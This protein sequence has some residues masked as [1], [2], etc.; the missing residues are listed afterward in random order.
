MATTSSSTTADPAAAP[1]ASPVPPFKKTPFALKYGPPVKPNPT[2]K[3]A[4]AEG[5]FRQKDTMPVILKSG[6]TPL[7]PMPSAAE[8]KAGWSRLEAF[9]RRQFYGFTTQELIDVGAFSLA[10][11]NHKPLE[12]PIHPVFARSRWVAKPKKIYNIEN[13]YGSVP[14]SGQNDDVWAILQPSLRLATFI[15]NK[16][17]D[18]PWVSTKSRPSTV[19]TNRRSRWML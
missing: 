6:L 8:D 19:K 5:F 12:N 2:S 9:Q 18:H 3:F 7:S 4:W 1:P 10:P 16:L 14:W 15:L 17:D 11:V 13:G